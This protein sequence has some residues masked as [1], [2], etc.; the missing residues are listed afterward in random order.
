[1]SFLLSYENDLGKITMSK[2]HQYQVQEMNGL[3][4]VIAVSQS[5]KYI[6]TP[7]Q[8]TLSKTPEPRTIEI[9]GRINITGIQ[10]RLWTDKL[11]KVFDNTVEGTLKLDMWGKRRRIKCYPD[12]CVISE[13]SKTGKSAFLITL[14]CDDPYFAD[15]ED[16]EVAL[17]S[18][19]DKINGTFRLPM[20]FTERIAGGTAINRG[21]VPTEPIIII[22][23]GAVGTGQTKGVLIENKTTGKDIR[24]NYASVEDE[25]ITI[26]VAERRIK[27]NINGDITR[28]K[29]I[30]YKLSDF[31]FAVGI[32]EIKFSN[33]DTT[34][35]LT[36]KAIFANKYT[37]AMW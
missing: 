6:K 1:M 13:P 29:P 3:E 28:Y 26:N 33:F 36:A 27:S 25:I 4:Q 37:E 17:F 19:T 35:P 32:N 22:T 30:S 11:L 24:L 16:V 23:A 31:T 7:G 8:K 10:R 20:V 21:T 5:I 14:L 18:R 15:W 2:A 12:S 9:Q 34:Q